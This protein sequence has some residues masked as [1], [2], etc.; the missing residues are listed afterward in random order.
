MASTLPSHSPL[1]IP[2]VA[3]VVDSSIKLALEWHHI[4]HA[5]LSQLF[6]RLV[7]GT[8]ASLPVTFPLFFSS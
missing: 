2:V 6:G 3:I 8:P 7:S 5:Y 1:P 4:L